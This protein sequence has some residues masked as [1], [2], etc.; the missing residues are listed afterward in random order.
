IPVNVIHA[1]P[2]TILYSL[3]GLQEIIDWEKIMKLQS[4]DGS[5]LSSPASTAAVFMRTGDRKCL[6]FLSFVL[7]KFADH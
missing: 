5:F 6:D 4:K 2:T 1:I 3:E 7:N